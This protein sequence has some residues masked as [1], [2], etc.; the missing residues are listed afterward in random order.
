MIQQNNITRYKICQS[1]LNKIYE[2]AGET[3][4]VLNFIQ[5]KLLA[6]SYTPNELLAREIR[7]MTEFL[8]NRT[9][10]LNK[11]INEY[12]YVLH[13]LSEQNKYLCYY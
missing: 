1:Y 8:S 9:K 2:F 5:M 3:N 7:S 10:I 13:N 11:S 6:M 4:D 12:D